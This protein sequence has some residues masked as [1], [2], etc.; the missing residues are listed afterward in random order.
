[1][2]G[3][4]NVMAAL[5]EAINLEGS[6]ALQYLLDARNVKRYGLKLAKG[7]KVLHEQCETFGKHLT[8]R[9]LFLEGEPR[10][11]LAA[12]TTQETVTAIINT[13]IARETALIA[14]YNAI[15]K[16]CYDAGDMSNFHFF[17][18]L[19]RWH[20]EGDRAKRGHLD[21]LEKQAWQI[22]EWGESDYEQT[23]A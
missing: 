18:H 12:A 5:Q 13:A 10:V 4:A 9:L 8:D 15:V 6:L 17:Q 14:R 23:K 11:E 2:R 20:S 7:L 3:N 19:V 1:M 22:K 16:I 21:W